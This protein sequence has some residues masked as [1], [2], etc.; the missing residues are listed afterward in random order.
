MDAEVVVKKPRGLAALSPERRAEVIAKMKATK[1]AKKE[2]EWAEG[3]EREAKITPK[4]GARDNL[5]IKLDH[6]QYTLD[7]QEQAVWE[8]DETISPL[9]VPKSIKD[10][11]PDM[12]WHWV[13]SRT[14]EVKGRNYHGWQLFRSK[15]YPEGVNR[16]NDLHLAAMPKE[17]AQSYRDAVANRSS[18]RV[19]DL[20]GQT[21]G[22]MEKALTDMRDPGSGMIGPGDTVGGKQVLGGI[23]VGSRGPFGRGGNYQRGMSRSEL[24]ERLAK[25]QEERG[26]NKKYVDLGRR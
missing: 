1:A 23:E 13:S 16:G 9:H 15:E 2:A 20:Q 19:R 25:I 17:L 4:I 5:D 12:E 8:Q 6:F 10:R 14:V 11:Y 26:K 18:E 3:P 22:K 21:I 7:P 24:Y